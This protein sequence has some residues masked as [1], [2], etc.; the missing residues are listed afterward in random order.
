MPYF[1]GDFTTAQ[2][3]IMRAAASECAARAGVYGQVDA[4]RDIA[5][6]I[7]TAASKG[8]WDMGEL[9]AAGLAAVP[10]PPAN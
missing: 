5:I 7:L 3:H 4:E 1:R 9:V 6:A 8:I 2:L 10:Q